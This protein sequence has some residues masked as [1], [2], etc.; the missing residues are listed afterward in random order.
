MNENT[1][2]FLTIFNITTGSG[3]YLD[4]LR[5]KSYHDVRNLDGKQIGEGSRCEFCESHTTIGITKFKTDA[6]GQGDGGILNIRLQDSPSSSPVA[7][8]IRNARRG[9]YVT[10]TEDTSNGP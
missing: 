5:G 2:S 4:T 3:K 8:P 9:R 1:D 10:S 6:A 7:S